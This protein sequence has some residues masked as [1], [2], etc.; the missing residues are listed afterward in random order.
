MKK[1]NKKM[2]H[3]RKI[4]GDEQYGKWNIK[5]KHM[6]TLNRGKKEISENEMLFFFSKIIHTCSHSYTL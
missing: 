6:K 2:N 4:D 5:E 3:S 1:E